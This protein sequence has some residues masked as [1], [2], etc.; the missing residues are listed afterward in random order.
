M[1]VCIVLVNYNGL[2]DTLKC[3]RSLEAVRDNDVSTV[4]VDNDSRED[5][6]ATI[7]EQFPWCP[8][9]RNS[10]NGGWAG[11][12]N[13]GIRYALDR[14]AD[15]VLLLNNDT[16][17]APDMVQTL[18]I[19]VQEFPAFGILG[20]VIYF[21]DEPA[22]V[23]TDGCLF[24]RSG[25]NGF[26]QRKA[27]PLDPMAPIDVTEVDIVN[28]CAMLIRTDVFRHIGLIDERF[29]LIHEESDFCLRACKAGFRC[30]VL[31]RGLVWHKGSSTF[32]RTGKRLQRYYD[33]RNLYLLL[34]KHA[35]THGVGRGMLTSLNQYAKYAY[36]RYVVEQENDCPESANAVLEGVWDAL[37]G[38][39]GPLSPRHRSGVPMLCQCLEVFR[40]FWSSCQRPLLPNKAAVAVS[41]KE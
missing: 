32:N 16:I 35:R 27:V 25:Y 9:V 22:K 31:N 38:R 29:F 11:G 3:L 28:G 5:P 2:K 40:K 6:S 10:V 12:N 8:V 19:A 23:M 37:A 4:L 33:A 34:I 30:G 24:N 13:T 21:M 18:R 1:N 17:V 41:T 7:A 20:P 15:L 39:F 14:G 36:Y 26:F